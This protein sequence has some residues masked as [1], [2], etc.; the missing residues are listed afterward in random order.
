MDVLWNLCQPSSW[1]T[2]AVSVYLPPADGCGGTDGARLTE[3]DVVTF[4][5]GG[6]TP[7]GGGGNVL[8]GIMPT[9]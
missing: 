6:L 8:V 5:D 1:C 2:Q 9:V 3:M 7:P 4:E